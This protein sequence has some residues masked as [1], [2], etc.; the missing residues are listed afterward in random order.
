M[1]GERSTTEKTI[2]ECRIFLKY[3]EQRDLIRDLGVR[4][5]Q[6]LICLG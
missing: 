5:L 4:E 3:H 2:N 1:D 6:R